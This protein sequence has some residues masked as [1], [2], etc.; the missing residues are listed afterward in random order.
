MLF[1][2]ALLANCSAS[3][4]DK[5]LGDDMDEAEAVA[6]ETSVVIELDISNRIGTFISTEGGGLFASQGC[7]VGVGTSLAL[8][9]WKMVFFCE[10]CPSGEEEEEEDDDDDEDNSCSTT[11]EDKF[12]T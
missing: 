10:A 1:L 3:S 2:E 9:E 5:I 11:E 4:A 12:E 8:G 6:G 7:C